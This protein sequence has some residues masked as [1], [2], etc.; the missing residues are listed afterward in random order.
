MH[1]NYHFL[2]QL[3]PHLAQQ[4]VGLE[5]SSCFSQNRDELIII[6]S[7]EDREF[8][9]KAFL[10]QAF[11]C[12]SFPASFHR[13]RKNSVDIFPS[14]TASR[15]VE[16][17]QFLNERAFSIQ[18]EDGHQ[19]LFKMHGNRSNVVL[20]DR[21]HQ[22]ESLFIN[23][24]QNDWKI[25]TT[26]LDRPIDQSFEAFS[27]SEGDVKALFPT[28]NK[29]MWQQ[30]TSMLAASEDLADQ[31]AILKQFV[32]EL[33]D[34]QF[35]YS[36]KHFSLITFSEALKVST[37][38]IQAITDFFVLYSTSRQLNELKKSITSALS[39]A[40]KK[41][42]GYI[43]KASRKLKELTEKSNYRV[44]GD[45]IMANMHAINPGLKEV[46]VTNFYDDNNPIVIPLKPTLSA[47]KNAELF[48][49]K[50]KNQS[51]ELNNLKQNIATKQY[52]LLHLE[53]HLVEVHQIDDYK[54]LKQYIDEHALTKTLDKQPVNLPYHELEIDGFNVW[55][56]KNA[57]ANDSMLKMAYKDDLWLHAKD[58]AGSHVIIKHQ[59]GKVI[60]AF[61][62]EKAAQLAAFHSKRKTDSLCPVIITP[63]KYVRKRKG[64]RPGAV[65]VEREEVLLVTP[66]NHR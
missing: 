48:Y 22:V 37:D 47:Q 10:S 2:K 19:L 30:A 17:R 45:L 12:L 15:V 60:P 25:D 54:V 8:I 4:L 11:C 5:L 56:G 31:F 57:Q 26:T 32:N 49:R 46:T 62:K 14:L 58:V 55:L 6:F 59:S 35:H 65:I 21:H 41:S 34:G 23:S 3:T 20:I 51:I 66:V 50:A 28:F 52:E 44:Y 9:I 40:S 27:Q 64:D 1:N 61:V 38:P 29:D 13:A 43:H 33:E 24:L 18:F 53:T 16:V 42:Q 39:I 7:N 63:R 36:S